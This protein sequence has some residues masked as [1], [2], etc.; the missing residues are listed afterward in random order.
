MVEFEGEAVS[1]GS[2]DEVVFKFEEDVISAG[3]ED[4]VVN[5]G[6]RYKYAAV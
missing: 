4:E 6:L 1:E 2:E 5:D 3:P